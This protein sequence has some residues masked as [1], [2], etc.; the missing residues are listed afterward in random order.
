M[1]IPVNFE[2][3]IRSILSSGIQEPFLSQILAPEPLQEFF[4]RSFTRNLDKFGKASSSGKLDYE[5]L[6]AVGDRVLK[7]VFQM[8]LFEI[9]GDTVTIPQPYADMEKSLLDTKHLSM[10]ADKLEFNKIVDLG[11][12]NIPNRMIKEDMFESLVAAIVLSGDK[13]VAQDFG[14]SLAKRWL[15]TVFKTHF[16]EEIDI[17]NSSKYVDYRTQISEIWGFNGWGAVN[18]STETRGASCPDKPIPEHTLSENVIGPNHKTFPSRFRGK[19]IGCGFGYSEKTAREDAA[20]NT[21]D[22]LNVNYKDIKE[23]E[24]TYDKLSM[25]RLQKTLEQETGLYNKLVAIMNNPKTPFDQISTRDIQISG[26][27]YVQIRVRKENTPWKSYARYHV[28][29]STKDAYI[30]AFKYFISIV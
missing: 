26:A 4:L 28:G 14:L 5:V 13:Y 16:S 29:S 2:P 23:H 8:Y 15:Y 6:E 10:L 3:Y 25:L 11:P 18:Y 24:F 19:I 1:S 17:E 30:G 21:L 22:V 7:T 20:R 12:D 27:Y 9:M